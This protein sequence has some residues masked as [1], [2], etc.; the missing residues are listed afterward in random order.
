LTSQLLNEFKQ[1]IASLTLIPSGGGVFE[2][3]FD[4]ELVYSKAKT[5][6]FPKEDAIMAIARKKLRKSS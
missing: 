5:G 4:D 6:S 3:E 1:E 2:V